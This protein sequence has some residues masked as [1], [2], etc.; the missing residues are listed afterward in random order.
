MGSDV[1][2][3]ELLEP[4][5]SAKRLPPDLGQQSRLGVN[6]LQYHCMVAHTP[7]GSLPSRV[8]LLGPPRLSYTLVAV[9]RH[10]PV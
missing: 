5:P 2:S 10:R 3:S 9:A 6:Q 7:L 8:C 1:Q 4:V